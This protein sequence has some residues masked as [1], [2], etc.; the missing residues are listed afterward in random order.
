MVRGPWY[1]AFPLAPQF[2]WTFWPVLL[3]RN[4][5]HRSRVSSDTRSTKKSSVRCGSVSS[6]RILQL[7]ITD[8]FCINSFSFCN[9]WN[10]STILWSPK[11]IQVWQCVIGWLLD[12]NNYISILP[13]DTMSGS[14]WKILI[15]S[16]EI[17]VSNLTRYSL[18]SRYRCWFLWCLKVFFWKIMK[19]LQ[20]NLIS[21]WI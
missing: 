14:C 13:Q 8:S 9:S 3:S 12:L 2:R 15:R 16:R 7:V 6:V 11:S 10:P 19:M 1:W 17:S 4:M 18:E 20:C 5:S 21:C